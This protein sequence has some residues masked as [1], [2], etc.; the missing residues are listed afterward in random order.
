M[1]LDSYRLLGRSGLRVSPLCLGAMTFGSDWGWGA[2]VDES[3]RMFD[4]Y[5]DRGGNFIDTAKVARE[6]GTSPAQI[7]LAWTLLNP[8][9]VSPIVGARTSAQLEENLQALEVSLTDD[10]RARLDAI[11]AIEMGFPH[12]FLRRPMVRTVVFGGV[13]LAGR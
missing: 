4:T 8:G 13:E 10:Q 6:A 2:D 9:V 1:R 3:R 7:A 11:S 5:V 12:D